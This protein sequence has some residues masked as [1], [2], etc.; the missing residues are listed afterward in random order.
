MIL[1][2]TMEKCEY[3]YKIEKCGKKMN[4]AGNFVIKRF[5][6]TGIL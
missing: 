3:G 6:T 2:Y 5:E 1:F 4:K